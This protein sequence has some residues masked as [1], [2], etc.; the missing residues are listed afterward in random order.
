MKKTS[1]KI[2]L[3]GNDE[4]MEVQT[5]IE[6]ERVIHEDLGAYLHL[7][8]KESD[9][10]GK[11][12]S[13]P[14]FRKK[15]R[16]WR[17]LRIG[18]KTLVSRTASFFKDTKR[19]LF[20]ITII[21]ATGVAGKLLDWD[22]EVTGGILVLLGI[23]SSVFSWLGA[24][25]LSLIAIIPIIGPLVVTI[26]SSSIL[27]VING[28]GYFVSVVAIKAGHGK[29]VLNYRLLVLVFLTGLVSGYVIAKLV[30]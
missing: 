24:A 7:D 17:R 18:R 23:I 9:E 6:N 29:T 10:S 5:G 30:N 12:I 14:V 25:I 16:L 2:P 13:I 21:I 27:W 11:E 4:P 20:F 22:D 26:L 15:R 19:M 3:G 28:L 8:I 1:D